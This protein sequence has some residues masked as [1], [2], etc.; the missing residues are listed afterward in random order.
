MDGLFQ[1]VESIEKKNNKESKLFREDGNINYRQMKFFDAIYNY[2]RAI[3]FA[4]T[5]EDLALAYGNRSAVCLEAGKYEEC[6][7]NIELAKQTGFP[8]NK[9]QQLNQREEKCKK[10]MREQK[11]DPENNLWSYIILSYPA[12][13]K[14]PWMIK[15][16]EMRT[17]EEFDRG[18]YTSR[19]LKAGDI[20]CIEESKILALDFDAFFKCCNNCAKT[21]MMTLIP[22]LK[23]AT[24]MF[25]STNCRDEF[26]KYTNL[27]S[28]KF[29]KNVLFLNKM[30]NIFGGRENLLQYLDSNPSS[31]IFDFDFS[32]LSHSDY[33]L[34][35]YKC[36][37]SSKSVPLVYDSPENFYPFEEKLSRIFNEKLLGNAVIITHCKHENEV[38]AK[39]REVIKNFQ[40]AMYR[41]EKPCFSTF[42]ALLN[43]SCVPN[44][45]LV[46]I[47]NTVVFYVKKPIKTNEQL[48]I[49]YNDLNMKQHRLFLDLI[50]VSNCSC[51]AC[52]QNLSIN[53]I[54]EKNAMQFVRM[55]NLHLESIEI[56]NVSHAMELISTLFDILNNCEEPI[57]LE[58]SLCGKFIKKIF[59]SLVDRL[60]FP[61]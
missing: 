3:V 35:L 23:T 27:A 34:N 25:C 4:K 44:I 6:L 42:R 11:K 50:G 39:N 31:S 32:D 13:E 45:D 49:A 12:N 38:T 61:V 36:F 53:N 19:N 15:D 22:C 57:L 30:I 47:N 1:D 17:N 8:K 20:V 2:N 60:M 28:N 9:V 41:A 14:I 43:H 33:M 48:F 52:I 46:C 54:N 56:R 5:K 24:F 16:L 40:T 7:K 51:I 10:L 26:Y 58:M 29:Y 37:L 21:S 55:H 59:N 18:I